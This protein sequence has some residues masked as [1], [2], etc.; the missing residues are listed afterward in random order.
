M[1]SLGPPNNV[2]ERVYTIEMLIK[3]HIKLLVIMA[4]TRQSRKYIKPLFW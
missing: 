2:R 1:R 3:A 4:S